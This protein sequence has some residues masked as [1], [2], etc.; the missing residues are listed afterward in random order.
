MVRDLD[1]TVAPATAATPSWLRA[2]SR[3]DRA[4]P[5][6]GVANEREEE[7]S[8][9]ASGEGLMQP[10][11]V[12]GQQDD[13]EQEDRIDVSQSPKES[14]QHVATDRNDS[15]RDHSLHAET[16]QDARRRGIA[17]DFCPHDFLLMETSA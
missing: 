3:I 6:T 4:T 12:D 5:I 2:T 13:V 17:D 11:E 10:R 9:P 15:Q 1:I 14:E 7:R 8:G 16:G